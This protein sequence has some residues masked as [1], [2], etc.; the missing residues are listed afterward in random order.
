MKKLS[1]DLEN[2]YGITKLEHIFDFSE[3]NAY[4]VYAPNGS[5]KSSFAKTLQDIVD[6]T[7]SVDRIYPALPWHR[8]VTDENGVELA[9]ND[10]LVLIPYD[11]SLGHTEKTSTLLV[12]DKLRK[13]YETL[14]GELDKVKNTLI[15]ALKKQ[16][17]SKK[18]LEKE[19]SDTFRK[20]HDAFYPALSFIKE[21]VRDGKD[22]VFAKVQYDVIFDDKVLDFL[23]EKETKAAIQEYIARYNELIA[24]STYFKRGIFEYYNASEIAKTLAEHGF[25][26]AKHTVVLNAGEK[27]EIS[28]KKDLEDLIAEELKRITDDVEL[29]KKFD[30][31]KKKLEKNATLRA[32]HNYIVGNPLLVPHLSN[33]ALFRD[34][35]WVSY[36]KSQRELFEAVL[37]KRE[38]IGPK[39][40]AIEAEARKERCNE[41]LRF[42]HVGPRK[43][44]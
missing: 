25:F 21:A 38:E 39:M 29:K 36:L 6:G 43:V 20:T 37:V 22:P 3:R 12:N 18:D 33:V 7:P 16:S 24:T 27:R 30:A 34:Q 5:M 8:K 15:E 10:L 9:K 28:T 11:A 1:I 23:A 40:E 42:G 2:C 35:I 44:V 41:P 14:Q 19:I 26:T 13:E 31:L 4:A 17:G 32:F